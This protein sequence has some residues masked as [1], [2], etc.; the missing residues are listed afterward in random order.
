MNDNIVLDFNKI[1]V[2]NILYVKPALFYDACYNIGIYY[3]VTKKDKKQKII[4]KTPKMIIPFEIKK[5][6][7]NGNNKYN[8][9]LSLRKKT[10]L[11]NEQDIKDFYK[12]IKKIDD[13][14]ISLLEDYR[15]DWKLPKKMKYRKSI[16]R[17]S[18]DFPHHINL[19]LP[20]DQDYGFMFS[21]YDEKAKLRDINILKKKVI[22]SAI[23]ELTDLHFTDKLCFPRWN[24]VQVRKFNPY[25]PIQELMLTKCFIFDG[26]EIIVESPKIVRKTTQLPPT[27]PPPPSK[28]IG[29]SIFIP[30]SVQEL[31][32]AMKKLKTVKTIDKT[33]KIIENIEEPEKKKS[34]KSN[35][36][37]SEKKKK[38]NYEKPQKSK[39]SNDEES[40]KKKS[41]KSNDEEP[42]KSKK[43]NDERPEK[44]KSKKSNNRESI[45]KHKRK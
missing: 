28:P 25:S 7:N 44:K 11:Y 30:P 20:H 13:T 22:V 36:E 38:S 12:F 16:S 40:E 8:L 45:K 34:K 43:S 33:K 26:D 2:D 41:R 21:V 17:L 14:N 10:N 35:D 27:P 6:D 24:V 3:K 39:K 19:N 29:K 31:T 1:N 9:T 23:I 15:K 42:E 18:Y 37:E 4:I 32:D 5:F